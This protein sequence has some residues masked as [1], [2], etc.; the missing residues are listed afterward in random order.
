MKFELKNNKKINAELGDVVIINGE[1]HLIIK[2]KIIIRERHDKSWSNNSGEFFVSERKERA[3]YH[4]L[5]LKTNEIASGPSTD[6]ELLLKSHKDVQIIK[7]NNLKLTAEQSDS[8]DEY[9]EW[10]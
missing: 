2:Q 5:N 10:F 3:Y 9:K 1:P 8:E 7:A 4:L 6:I